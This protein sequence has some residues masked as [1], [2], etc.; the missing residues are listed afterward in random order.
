MIKINGLSNIK[1]IITLFLT[2]L[3]VGF[4]LITIFYHI[5]AKLKFT[6]LELKNNY[7]KSKKIIAMVTDNG[8]WI[9]DEYN[10]NVYIISAIKL[11]I[12][13]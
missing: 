10:E 2:S 6:Y 4:F 7:S 12:I 11:K 3:I 1:I 9:K 8:I 13:T 5:S